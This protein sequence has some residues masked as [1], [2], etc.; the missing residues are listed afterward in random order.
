VDQDGV[1]L[2]VPDQSIP[3]EP[4]ALSTNPLTPQNP[5]VGMTAGFSDVA[6]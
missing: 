4:P 6:Q 2:Q 3:F 1:P 5:D